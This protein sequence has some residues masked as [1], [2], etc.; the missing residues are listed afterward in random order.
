MCEDKGLGVCCVI[1]ASAA[2]QSQK[3]FAFETMALFWGLVSILLFYLVAEKI[4]SNWNV[5]WVLGIIFI[6]K[7]ESQFRLVRLN[8]ALHGRFFFFFFSVLG[9]ECLLIFIFYFFTSLHFL[10][11]QT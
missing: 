2:G 7:G 11:K 3:V 9:L 6:C 4:E 5:F 1:N 8:L 10:T